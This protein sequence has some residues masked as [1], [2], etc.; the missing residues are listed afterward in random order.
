MSRNILIFTML[1]MAFQK[2]PFRALI[3]R[4][5]ESERASFGG[6]NAAFWKTA[7]MML[8]YKVQNVACFS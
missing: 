5:L 6:R 7:V 8:F 2:V 3:C 4:L 1:Y